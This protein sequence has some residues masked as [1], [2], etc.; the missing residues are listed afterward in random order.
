MTNLYI[1]LNTNKINEFIILLNKYVDISIKTLCSD[2]TKYLEAI[3]KN[4][5]YNTFNVKYFKENICLYIST[6][7]FKYD[8]DMTHNKQIHFLN[9]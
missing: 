4:K 2:D 9:G 1:N 3:Y 5:L 6:L 7:K 8:F